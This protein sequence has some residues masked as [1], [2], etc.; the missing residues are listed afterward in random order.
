MATAA[1]REDFPA[2]G[3]WV[4]L[5]ESL[6]SVLGGILTTAHRDTSDQTYRA[7][8]GEAENH[9]VELVRSLDEI[10]GE[11]LRFLERIRTRDELRRMSQVVER[12]SPIDKD[13]VD[14]L[15]SL[16]EAESG[17]LHSLE[18]VRNRMAGVVDRLSSDALRFMSAPRA[19]A[20]RVQSALSLLVAEYEIYLQELEDIHDLARG[21]AALATGE[22]EPH[23]VVRKRL[24]LS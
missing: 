3:G 23:A 18:Q 17:N 6:L 13:D 9:A 5:V 24:S 10:E 2:F 14:Q 4:T 21:D 12:R 16:E 15:A 8:V 22:V 7:M 1:V 20:L 11:T 19:A